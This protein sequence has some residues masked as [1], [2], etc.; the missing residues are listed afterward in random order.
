MDDRLSHVE[1]TV[2]ELERSLAFV[3]ARLA[4]LERA[5]PTA[6]ADRTEPAGAAPVFDTSPDASAAPPV[7]RDDFVGV[8]SLIGRSFVALGGA[9]LLRALTDSAILPQSTGI[10]LGL[11]YALS[12]L[13]MADLASSAGRR[14]SA[15][16]HVL[17]ASTIAFPLLWEAT[18]RFRFLGPAESAAAITVVTSLAL[19]VAVR[20]RF[21]SLAWIVTLAALPTVLALVGVTGVVIPVAVFLILLGVGTL[22]I[23]YALE[24]VLLRWPVALVADITVL[25]LTLRV[26][27]R[28]WDE[29]P[30]PVVAVQLLLLTGYL[31]SIATRTLV[32]A[33]DV[34]VFEVAQSIAAL[35]VGFGG[36]V[37]VARVTG[38]GVIVVLALVNLM[39]GAGCYGVA[40]AF[41][42]RRQGLRRNFYFYTSLGLVLVLVSSNLLLGASTVALAWAAVAMLT[43]WLARE[44]QRALLGLHAAVYAIASAAASGLLTASA[45]ALVGP[46]T[47]AW[48]AFTPAAIVVL[49]AIAVCW[50]I[51]PARQTAHAGLY[52]RMPRVALAAV[53]VWSLSGWLVS[54]LTPLLSLTPDGGADVGIVATI[55]TAILAGGA[56]GLAWAGRHARFREAAWLLYPVLIAG[57]IKLLVE[58]MPQS[59]PATLFLA[60]ALYGGALIAAPRLTRRRVVP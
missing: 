9:Y 11:A 29:L 60:L 38:S 39:I 33:R 53:L 55:R 52:A 6:A 36:A 3:E 37:Y 42:A 28:S 2:R 46:V 59:R 14:M 20:Q 15:A 25:A 49:T 30:A 40:Y 17:V 26:S 5:A 34:N 13:V 32:R 8:L 22:W 41:V 58:D 16:F 21:Q 23:G 19:G 7:V 47:S 10:A 12:W 43:A 50:A 18:V 45:Y 51:P 57:G 24:W 31:A 48:G 54:L 56:L 4:A 35:A 44:L 27:N 1:S